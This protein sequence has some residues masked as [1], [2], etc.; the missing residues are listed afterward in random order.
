MKTGK[1]H[2]NSTANLVNKGKSVE[3][4]YKLKIEATMVYA[5]IA[6]QRPKSAEKGTTVGLQC[7][8]I[9]SII[10]IAKK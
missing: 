10:K 2:Y 9:P 1:W 4:S 3:L 7:F 5:N 6:L 8:K